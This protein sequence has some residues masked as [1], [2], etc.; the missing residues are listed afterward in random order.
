VLRVTS[1]HRRLPGQP[2]EYFETNNDLLISLPK[3][4]TVD[5]GTKRSTDPSP[6]RIADPKTAFVLNSTTTTTTAS[7][8]YTTSEGA[9]VLAPHY[10]FEILRA[11]M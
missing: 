9:I 1:C 3:A 4:V 5:R 2:C 6:G 8:Y 10:D 11:M 7:T